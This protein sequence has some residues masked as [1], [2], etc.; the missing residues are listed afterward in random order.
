MDAAVWGRLSALGRDDVWGG[1]A[2]GAVSFGG[3]TSASGDRVVVV[4]T[5][6][7]RVGGT[8]TAGRVGPRRAEGRRRSGGR[9]RRFG[10]ADRRRG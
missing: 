9:V 2:G 7:G 1:G 6:W 4:G 3:E 5:E 10:G 8:A